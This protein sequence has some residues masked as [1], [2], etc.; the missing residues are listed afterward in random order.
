[1]INLKDIEEKCFAYYR[2]ECLILTIKEEDCS[3]NCPFYKPT[4]CEDWIKKEE[5]GEIWLIP[6]EEYYARVAEKK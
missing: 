2:G 6:S 4:G 3:K 1:M 5:G